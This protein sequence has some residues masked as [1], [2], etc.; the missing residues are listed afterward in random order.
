V[1]LV[2]LILMTAWLS[3]CFKVAGSGS[4]EV[5]ERPTSMLEYY[6]PAGSFGNYREEVEYET[7]SYIHK[8]ITIESYA[9]PIT[10]EY[11]QRK[12]VRSDSMVFVFPVLGGK[13]F[14]EKHI[15]HSQQRVQG[16]DEV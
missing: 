13:N 9:G 2:I 8:R 11:F 10:A 1:R 16:S 7:D 14:I 12:G 15:A 3:G 6:K 4:G 5:L